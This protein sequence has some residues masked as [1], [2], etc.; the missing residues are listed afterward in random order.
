MIFNNIQA[1][2]PLLDKI[3][4]GITHAMIATSLHKTPF[5]AL[6]RPVSGV[7]GKTIILTVP[8]SPKG[9]KEN[10]EAVINIL[11]HA[12]DLVRGGTGE[13][14]HM[15]LN[16]MNRSGDKSGH[17]CVHTKHEHHQHKHEHDTTRLL[18]S[19]PLSGPGKYSMA[20]Y[21]SCYMIISNNLYCSL[22]RS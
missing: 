16:P 7:R 6:S 1:I 2:E 12:V 19:D 11:T 10:L 18:L 9:A 20:C 4:S 15:Q 21:F 5:A 8:G 22:Y 14:V 13:N 3:S 17:D